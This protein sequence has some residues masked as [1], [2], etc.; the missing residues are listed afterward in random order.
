MPSPA[1]PCPLPELT[2]Y[3]MPLAERYYLLEAG[4]ST[5]PFSLAVLRQKAE[6]HVLKPDDLVHPADHEA[7]VWRPICEETELHA[8]LFPARPGLSLGAA[9]AFPAVNPEQD[10]D[11]AATHVL[12]LLRDN[13]EREAAARAEHDV[14]AAARPD[15]RGRNRRR[16]F[17]TVVIGGNLF[18]LIA[19]AIGGFN[20]LHGVFVAGFM[21]ILTAG[22]YWVLYH[23]MDPY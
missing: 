2:P 8:S 5:G 14:F 6:I 17:W 12:G 9:T 4:V 15:N 16:D 19:F 10:L 1:C 13:A 3:P 23:V 20:P 11:T 22:T 18:A 7:T 21:A